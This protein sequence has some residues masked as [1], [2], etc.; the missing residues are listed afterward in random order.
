MKA[1]QTRTSS[2]VTIRGRYGSSREG[3]STSAHAASGV[4]RG[5][6]ERGEEH[7][8]LIA[9]VIWRQP[10]RTWPAADLPPA[11]PGVKAL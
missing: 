10:Q 5:A 1:G 3:N 2:S 4:A 8:Y 9:V 11:E 7:E 6:S